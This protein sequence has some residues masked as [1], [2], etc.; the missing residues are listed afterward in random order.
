LDDTTSPQEI[1]T[2]NTLISE[3]IL[4][5]SNYVNIENHSVMST[6]LVCPACYS[7]DLSKSLDIDSTYLCKFCSTEIVILDDTPTFKDADRINMTTRYTYSRRGHFIEAM[8]KYQ[9][10]H[11]VAMGTIHSVS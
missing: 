5:A 6:K 7:E 2:R 11:N 3:Y 4:I 8:K 1:H 9:G 10:K